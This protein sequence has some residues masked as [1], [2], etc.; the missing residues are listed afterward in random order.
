MINTAMPARMTA[1][2]PAVAQD[3]VT[4]LPRIKAD[5]ETCSAMNTPAAQIGKN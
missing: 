4:R 2:A 1:I 5:L 3:R